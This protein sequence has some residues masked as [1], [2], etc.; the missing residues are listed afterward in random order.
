MR[1]SPPTRSA[2]ARWRGSLP[3]PDFCLGQSTAD[4]QRVLVDGA[5]LKDREDSG[6]G[7]VL[8]SDGLG[9]ILINCGTKGKLLALHDTSLQM[10]RRHAQARVSIL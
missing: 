3:Q 10:D 8:R 2:D 5:V 1:D 9:L 4:P 7:W 6:K